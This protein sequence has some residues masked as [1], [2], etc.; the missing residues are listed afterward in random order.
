M[1][2][3]LSHPFGHL[4]F[5]ISRKRRDHLLRIIMKSGTHGETH[6]RFFLAHTIIATFGGSHDS[7]AI[8]VNL[9]LWRINH[10]A[11]ASECFV[12]VIYVNY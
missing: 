10:L 3:P 9:Y 7:L 8:C 4:S 11:S 6:I 12:S 1:C 2:E 5:F